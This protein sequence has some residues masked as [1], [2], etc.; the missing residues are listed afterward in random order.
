MNIVCK[1]ILN[2]LPIAIIF[3]AFFCRAA[4]V[5][6]TGFGLSLLVLSRISTPDSC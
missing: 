1:L 3:P 4:K 6:Y 5:D 2:V